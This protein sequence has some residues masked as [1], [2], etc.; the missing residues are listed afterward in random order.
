MLPAYARK[1]L[2]VDLSTAKIAKERLPADL[3]RNYVGGKGMGTRLLYDEVKPR[4]DPLS[5]EN[6]LIFTTGPATGTIMPNKGYI[7]CY[8]SPLTN[9]YG[10]SNSGGFFGAEIKQAGYDVLIV[11]GR[12]AKP[13]YLWIDDDE[14]QIK[15]AGDLWGK[16]TFETNA[17][18]KEQLGDESIKVARIGPAGEKL[19]RVASILN[20]YS[21]TAARGGPGAVAGSKNLKAI[22]VR[23][24]KN[25]EVAKIDDLLEFV[26]KLHDE[27]YAK[28]PMYKKYGTPVL[29]DVV[30][31]VGALPTRYWHKG[32]FSEYEKIDA[33]TMKAK[34]V[35][36]NR[37]CHSC[38][39]PCGK[40]S[41][42]Q[43]GGTTL[44]GPEYE[45]LVS[46]GS[47]CENS[48]L[49]ALAKA[50]ELCDKFGMDTMDT[51]NLIAFAMDCY[52]QGIIA[53]KDAEGIEL[54]WGNHEA[55]VQFVE[56][57]AMRTGLG[58][59]L[60]EGIV[61]AAKRIGKG[62]E[63]IAVH[64]K[65]MA[66][67]GYDPRS[68]RGMALAYG[69][70]DRC[71][72][73]LPATYYIFAIRGVVDRLSIEGNATFIADLGVR[74]AASDT[75]ILCRFSR[76][77]IPWEDLP[78]FSSLLWGA[79]TSVADWKRLGERIITLARV[80]NVREGISRKDDVLPQRFFKEPVSKGPALK[81]SEVNKMLD[82]YYEAMGWDK[83]GIPTKERLMKL[84][85]EDAADEIE[86]LIRKNKEATYA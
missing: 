66:P 70:A 62:A 61:R 67:A 76:D 7:V 38:V 58:D 71:A 86:T 84:G 73:H 27:R 44:E 78:K 74:H 79:E 81:K 68:L 20:D 52:E 46:L 24:T 5:P 3:I 16:D 26:K 59:I 37:A 56:K 4:I 51:G 77:A 8:K 47:L 2:R 19:V 32:E 11:E 60:A 48:N 28:L 23:G 45:T 50:N 43:E 34:M 65:G 72:C 75:L 54:V 35:V 55:V 57:I 18:I 41:V 85:L 17:V 29:V 49:E 64:V 82:E 36:A 63:K 22:A 69:I 21:R 13:V 53:T 40:I 39:T 12:S 10:D 15:D 25:I 80:F 83:N 33:E 1:I 42:I 30:N 6:E 31:E 9:I 14:V